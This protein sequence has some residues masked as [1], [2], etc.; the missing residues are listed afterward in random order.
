[1]A[2]N[3]DPAAG[4]T[5]DEANARLAKYGSNE[6]ATTRRHSIGA[7]IWHVLANP[8]VLILVIAAVASAFLG[9]V[10]DAGLITTIVIISAA[11]DM[12][13][14]H[15][16]QAAVERLRDRVAPIATVL[17]G[18]KWREIQRR[19]LVPG[20]VVRLS[21]GD[22]IPGDARLLTARD[23]FVQQA[24]LTGESLPAEK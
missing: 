24:S 18:G 17:R 7:D 5:T 16:S 9:E 10:V 8:L 11:I 6:P 14:T 22:L 12:A 3:I 23:L 19:D 13:Q 4:L 1:M 21:A 20:D 2:D 15:R